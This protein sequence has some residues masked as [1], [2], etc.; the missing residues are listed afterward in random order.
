[1]GLYIDK[2]F[3]LDP[4]HFNF[5]STEPCPIKVTNLADRTI[6]GAEKAIEHAK[7]G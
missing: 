4:L 3:K 6:I 2:S 1:M 7:T 5:M